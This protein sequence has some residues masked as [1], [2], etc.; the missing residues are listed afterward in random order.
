MTPADFSTIHPILTVAKPRL[1]AIGFNIDFQ[2]VDWATVVSRRSNKDAWDMFASWG[3]MSPFSPA[4]F[5]VPWVE[6]W[7]DPRADDLRNA[8]IE[9]SSLDDQKSIVDEMQS[10]SYQVAAQHIGIGQ[11]FT[12]HASRR[13]MQGYDNRMINPSFYNV[14]LEK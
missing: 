4:S 14:W 3:S 2:V 1:E 10:L 9:S 8:F 11:F 5:G 6:G 13:W 12:Y 7:T